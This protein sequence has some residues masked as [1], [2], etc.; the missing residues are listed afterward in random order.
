[1]VSL[2]KGSNLV[3][4]PESECKSAGGLL[5]K[6]VLLI[7]WNLQCVN[8][9]KTFSMHWLPRATENEWP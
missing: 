4:L 6:G 7:Q 1:M 8:N 3:F 5:A 9:V 2:G